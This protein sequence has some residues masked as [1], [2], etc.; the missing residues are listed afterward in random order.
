MKKKVISALL[1]STMILSSA[2]CSKKENENGKG[3]VTKPADM[4]SETEDDPE[5][6]DT[7]TEPDGYMFSKQSMPRIGFTYSCRS[8]AVA[9]TSVLLNLPEE[10][11]K[12]Y[13]DRRDDALIVQDT[14]AAIMLEPGI[15]ADSAEELHDAFAKDAIVFIVNKDNPVDAISMNDLYKIYTGEIT[16]WKDLGGND[17]AI[18]AF[19]EGKSDTSSKVLQNVFG[20]EMSVNSP[21]FMESGDDYYIGKARATYDLSSESIGFIEYS[22]LIGS[23]W[24]NEVK[25]LKV[26]DVEPTA[27][28]IKNDDYPVTFTLDVV[29]SKELVGKEECATL[30]NWLLSEDGRKLAEMAGYIVPE[31]DPTGKLNGPVAANWSAF[32]AAVKKEENITRLSDE[33][34]TEF[35]PSADYGAVIPFL[36]VD[37]ERK[38]LEGQT[39][40]GLAD[41][42]GRVI[43]DPVFDRAYYLAD[44]SLLV[45]K[46]VNN[47]ER[48]DIDWKVGIISKDGSSFTG[49]IYDG[50]Y[51]DGDDQYLYT[52][53]E[54]GITIYKYDL[55]TA[56]VGE[57]KHLKMDTTKLYCFEGVIDERYVNCMNDFDGEYYLYD[58]TDGKNMPEEHS[59]V[60]GSSWRPAGSFICVMD[61][62]S[63]NG[64]ARI[65]TPDG[66]SLSDFVYCSCEILGDELVMLGRL[67]NDD[68]DIPSC[69]ELVRKDGRNLCVIDS[70]DKKITGIVRAG[71][72]L[73]ARKPEANAVDVYELTGTFLK[74]IE[75]EGAASAYALEL[76]EGAEYL[77][78]KQDQKL[79]VVFSL[80]DN[81]ELLNLENGNKALIPGSY[82]CE[83]A[84][85]TILLT[86]CNLDDPD[87]KL[88]NASDFSV[89]SEGKGST[90]LFKDSFENKFYVRINYSTTR[91]SSK[92]AVIRADDGS[93][94]A[95]VSAESDSWYVEVEQIQDGRIVYRE[96]IPTVEGGSISNQVAM[97][98]MS[99]NELLR[100]NTVAIPNT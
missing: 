7:D 64:G 42:Q 86:S 71:D 76:P 48:E 20:A 100:Y 9:A 43:C 67:D 51:T 97:I 90:Q 78:I 85:D 50:K 18:V 89:I 28:T 12:K 17:Q 41:L 36:G 1:V 80:D 40:Y 23:R 87:W 75:F 84:G 96:I 46:N 21:Y 77:A 72:Y 22:A 39:L 92:I 91:Y 69:Y 88:L 35:T 37:N 49:M 47:S 61:D 70:A 16:N 31:T 74:T 3:K 98:D 19:E 33:R 5:T 26:E 2:G 62:S 58:G 24:E 15:A 44:G 94:V 99:G 29:M 8:M 55:K 95:E 79:P 32:T 6:S 27:D 65:Y 25:I 56:K 53:E 34:I 68:P 30:Y 93:S 14:A 63:E 13:F 66:K 54:D 38:F 10:E 60:Y 4:E 81:T 83:Q 73:V 45:I 57:G 11:A 52:I 82:A 59:D